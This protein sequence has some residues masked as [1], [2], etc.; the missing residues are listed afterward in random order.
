[1][2]DTTI[3]KQA[4][5]VSKEFFTAGFNPTR[6]FAKPAVAGAEQ[7]RHT[8]RARWTRRISIFW[9]TKTFSGRRASGAR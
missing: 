8:D 6:D 9:S 7:Q 5:G 2:D 4:G 3:V 1:M